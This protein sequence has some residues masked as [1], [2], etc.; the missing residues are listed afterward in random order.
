MTQTDRRAPVPLA[1]QLTRF[2]L[3]GVVAAVVDYGLL[4]AGMNLAGWAHTPAKAVSWVFGTMT[5]YAL[6]SRW[7]FGAAGSRLKFA[8]VAVL[9]G[10][11][12]AV[13]VGTFALIYPPLEMALGT[14]AAQVVGF[15]I[16]QGLA[17]TINFVIQRTL[18]FRS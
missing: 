16:A 2:V 4:V 9:Y 1:T 6:N 15:V 17:T 12:F 11:T 13:Q 10:T 5:A 18:I 14:A 8:A 7:T 3:V